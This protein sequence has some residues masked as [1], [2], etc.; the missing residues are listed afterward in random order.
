MPRAWGRESELS[1]LGLV[2]GYSP[3]QEAGIIKA[4]NDYIRFARENK[5]SWWSKNVLERAEENAKEMSESEA[6]TEK[7]VLAQRRMEMLAALREIVL[8]AEM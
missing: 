7:A 2:K 8:Q 6:A 5:L 3:A 1:K 4:A